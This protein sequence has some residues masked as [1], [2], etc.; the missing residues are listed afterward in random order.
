MFDNISDENLNVLLDIKL[1][2]LKDEDRKILQPA[3]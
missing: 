3:I 1:G 2:S